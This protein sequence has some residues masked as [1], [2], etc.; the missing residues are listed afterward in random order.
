MPSVRQSR[1]FIGI[2]KKKKPF[3]KFNHLEYNSNSHLKFA[4]VER[5][6]YII[7]SAEFEAENF[8]LA[9]VFGGNKNNGNRGCS[10]IG[11]EPSAYF[12]TVNLRHHH[13]KQNNVRFLLGCYFHSF[14]RVLCKNRDKSHTVKMRL[15]QN[16]IG[17][18][19]INNK[20]FTL[21]FCIHSVRNP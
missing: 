11:F 20:D 5:L 12:K 8:V 15:E 3:L 10:D 18:A 13:V 7:N 14:D 4:F 16:K 6:G 2:C 19:I 17:L 9:L 1:K 21:C